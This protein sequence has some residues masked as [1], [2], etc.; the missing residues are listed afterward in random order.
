[1]A[2]SLGFVTYYSAPWAHHPF[3]NPKVC[4]NLCESLIFKALILEHLTVSLYVT[5]PPGCRFGI[6]AGAMA[7]ALN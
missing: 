6:Q 5:A 4:T 3:P 2:R 1:M 7:I